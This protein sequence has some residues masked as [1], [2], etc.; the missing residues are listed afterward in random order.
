MFLNF[1]QLLLV[2]F[3]EEIENVKKVVDITPRV[4]SI[5]KARREKYVDSGSRTS[6][7]FVEKKYS[8]L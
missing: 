3:F 4:G 2:I 5:F 6:G 8:F 1:C 7:R